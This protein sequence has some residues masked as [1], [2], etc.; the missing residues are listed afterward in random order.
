MTNPWD[1]EHECSPALARQLIEVQFPAFAPAE[2]QSFAEGWDNTAFLV[3]GS[4]VFRFPRRSVGVR[5][6]E[7]ELAV[8]PHLPN[9]S[10]PISRPSHIGK[11]EADFP[12][13][14]AGYP[15]LPGDTWSSSFPDHDTRHTNAPILGRFLRELHETPPPEGAIPDEWGRLDLEKRVPMFHEYAENLV[16]AGIIDSVAPWEFVIEAARAARLPVNDTLVHGDLYPKH[17]LLSDGVVSGVIDWGDVHLGDPAVDLKVAWM[18]LP[19]E[20]HPAFFDSYGS[21]DSDTRAL[22]RFRATYHCFL[23]A[24]YSIDVNEPSELREPL[25]ALNEIRREA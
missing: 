9:Y 11:P 8:L 10:L 23:S 13:P 5:C 19:L 18:F 15:I 25:R 4:H 22:A 7:L 20:A 21:V 3:N 24:S 17:V 1:A 16:A 6:M 2:V 14:W 12:F